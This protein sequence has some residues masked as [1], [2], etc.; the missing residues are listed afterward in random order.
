MIAHTPGP[1]FEPVGGYPGKFVDD[2]VYTYGFGN[3]EG[4]DNPDA[5]V[6][7]VFMF[8]IVDL[9]QVPPRTRALTQTR[10]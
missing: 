3:N 10:P 4:Q 2:G 1:E 7:Y 6:D 5:D 9:V 8:S